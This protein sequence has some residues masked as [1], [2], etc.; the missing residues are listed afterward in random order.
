[1]IITAKPPSKLSFSLITVPAG[2]YLPE[3]EV[4]QAFP[5]TQSAAH[6]LTDP[7]MSVIVTRAHTVITPSDGQVSKFCW[8]TI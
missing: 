4:Q 7:A 6:K 1:M 2:D 5:D 8:D 3:T